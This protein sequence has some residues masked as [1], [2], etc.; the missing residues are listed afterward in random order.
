MNNSFFKRLQF[1]AALLGAVGVMVGAFGAHFLKARLPAGDLETIKT[2]VLYLFIHTAAALVVCAFAQRT[3]DSRWLK[4]SGIAFIAGVVMFSGSLFIIGTS[5]LTGFPASAIGIITPL[6]G[7]AFILGWI[8][9]AIHG[10][11]K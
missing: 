11:K 6:G 1:L 2:G 9:L 3:P 4:T 5:G 7:L 8:F 10:G